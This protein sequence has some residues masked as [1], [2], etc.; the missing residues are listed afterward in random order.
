MSR[1][2]YFQC[3]TFRCDANRSKLLHMG[4]GS[5]QLLLNKCQLSSRSHLLTCHAMPCHVC[6]YVSTTYMDECTE[7]KTYQSRRLFSQIFF[8]EGL[9]QNASLG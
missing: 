7:N 2:N 8:I 9:D 4:V 5:R 6:M 3:R 1:D